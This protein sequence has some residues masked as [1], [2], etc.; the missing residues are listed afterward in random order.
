MVGAEGGIS[1]GGVVVADGGG[2]MRGVELAGGGVGAG[3]VGVSDGVTVTRGLGASGDNGVT[4][5]VGMT[6]EVEVAGGVVVS[7]GV[8]IS[9]GLAVT[10]GAGVTMG[11]GADR[12]NHLSQLAVTVVRT[13]LA[14]PRTATISRT[15]KVRGGIMS[16]ANRYVVGF[17][18]SQGIFPPQIIQVLLN[19]YK[20]MNILRHTT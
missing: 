13:T 17:C 7:D 5:G 18:S 14:N 11:A 9:G 12:E 15:L 10:Q 2:V 16:Q 6:R 8:G 20:N 4:R 19:Y 3:E 1:A